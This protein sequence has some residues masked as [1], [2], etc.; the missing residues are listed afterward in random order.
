MRRPL[1]DELRAP[2]DELRLREN[3]DGVRER[4]AARRRRP[5]RVAGAAAVLGLVALVGL[6]PRVRSGG[7]LMQAGGAPLSA[8]E[9]IATPR[10]LE[11][12]DGS[13]IELAAGTRLVP[14]RNAGSR[15]DLTLESG[16]ARF[17]VEPGGPRAWT[18]DAGS[19]RVRVVGTAFLV[20]RSARRVRVEVEHGRVAVEGTAVP[21]GSVLLGAG[22]A[23]EMAHPGSE[24]APPSAPGSAEAEAEARVPALPLVAAER[25]PD[26]PPARVARWRQVA[27]AEGAEA[28]YASIGEGAF[29]AT[30]RR[31]EP[32]QLLALADVA[33]RSGHVHHAVEPLDRL[34]REFPQHPE[35]PL[36]A[37]TL[38]RLQMGPLADPGAAL[39]TYAR[40]RDLGVPRVFDAE[41]CSGV[42]RAL[43]ATGAPDEARGEARECLRRHGSP[44]RRAE[45]ERILD[46]DE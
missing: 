11:L 43:V 41:V 44:P 7:P 9:A 32:D 20:E 27:D 42:A 2:D 16:R 30:A 28:A 31:T 40:A 38:A 1:A 19:A 34:V 15:I 17:E 8:T 46:A 33:R 4:V 3:W 39:R 35:A 37:I 24:P 6:W 12:A 14:T 13:R 21:G 36:A 26:A 29:S 25:E 5:R 10:A 23:W 22:E 45:L 18:I